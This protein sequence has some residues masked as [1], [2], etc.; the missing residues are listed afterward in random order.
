MEKQKFV[1]R[2]RVGG[3]VVGEPRPPK[4]A[5]LSGGTR[6]AGGASDAM[7]TEEVDEAWRRLLEETLPPDK[8]LSLMK[9]YS[10]ENDP[11]QRYN[12]L[13][14][15]RASAR[16]P[17]RPRRPAAGPPHPHQPTARARGSSRAT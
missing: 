13:L 11:R 15:V 8:Q 10:E 16:A 1:P 9:T 7:S 17:A 2:R 5:A 14:E 3:R 12:M 4:P 6:V